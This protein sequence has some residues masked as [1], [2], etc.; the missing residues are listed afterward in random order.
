M[1]NIVKLCIFQ[2]F[3]VFAFSLV[4]YYWFRKDLK[5]PHEKRKHAN[6]IDCLLFSMSVTSGTGVSGVVTTTQESN[7]VSIIQQATLIS[8]NVFI[9]YHMYS[10]L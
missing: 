5:L 9:I 7:I 10:A 1:K 6:Y 4:Y 8:S 2:F 3:C